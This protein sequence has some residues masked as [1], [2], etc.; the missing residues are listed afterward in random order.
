MSEQLKH[1]FDSSACLSKRQIKDYMSG[2]MTPEECHAVEHHINSCFFCSEALEGMEEHADALIVADQLDSTFLKDHFSLT[3]PQV[4]LNSMAPAATAPAMQRRNR[5]SKVQPLFRP[6]ALAAALILAF[7]VLWYLQYSKEHPENQAL[8]ARNASPAITEQKTA[9]EPV[10]DQ[11][12]A[13][14]LIAKNIPEEENRPAKTEILGA[15]QPQPVASFTPAAK[16]LGSDKKEDVVVKEERVSNLTAQKA[17]L[18]GETEQQRGEAVKMAAPVKLPATT[19]AAAYQ[20]KSTNEVTIS[21]ARSNGTI[22]TVDG[23]Q[24]QSQSAS[25]TDDEV[26]KA[27]DLYESGNYSEALKTYKKQMNE[28]SGSTRQH[29]TLMVARIYLKTGQ[30]ANAIK[31]LQSL[32]DEGSGPSRRQAKRLLKDLNSDPE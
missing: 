6:T 15:D 27:E 7:G 2:T 24:L 9:T 31:L 25:R 32:V 8:I 11:P 5:R 18:Q 17:A 10:D 29:A 14:T 13:A 16:D 22:Y 3:N 20:A 4:H 30:K 12:A 21:G 26:S 19:S 1:I 23:V 28:G